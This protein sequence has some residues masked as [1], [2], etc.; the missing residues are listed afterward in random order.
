MLPRGQAGASTTE[1][2][3]SP[4]PVTS[5]RVS[6]TSRLQYRPAC[7]A[8][9]NGL[10][11]GAARPYDHPVPG[12]NSCPASGLVFCMIARPLSGIR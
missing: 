6:G 2:P 9:A 7:H 8:R 5:L 12:Q 11:P 1:A 3:A 4:S 10:L